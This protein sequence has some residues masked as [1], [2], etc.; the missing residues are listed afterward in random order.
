[1]GESAPAAAA[2]LFT[3]LNQSGQ[4][5]AMG[6][7]L[8]GRYDRYSTQELAVDGLYRKFRSGTLY[9]PAE[10]ATTVILFGHE[11]SLTGYA[12]DW[13]GPHLLLTNNSG[14][15]W[16]L[17][18]D[19]A[20]Y[21][22]RAEAVLVVHTQRAVETRVFWSAVV[23]PI[24]TQFTASLPDE[25]VL[26]GQPQFGWHAFTAKPALSGGGAL[27]AKRIYLTVRQ[28]ITVVLDGWADYAAAIQFWIRLRRNSDGQAVGWVQRASYWVESGVFASII[29]QIVSPNLKLAVLDIN[30]AITAALA[31]ANLPGTLTDIYFLPGQT[32]AAGNGVTGTSSRDWVTD[33]TIVFEGVG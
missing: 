23:T 31:P 25:V 21:D 26:D 5:R 29:A 12:S 8:D 3:G 7:A 33:V 16:D 13:Q 14:S 27:D 22:K 17:N 1:M 30:D 10:G 2:L 18:L 20:D 4:A 15:E 9:K 28:K 19:E 24:V 6:T 32:P 11:V